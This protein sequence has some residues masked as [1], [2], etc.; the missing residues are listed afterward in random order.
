MRKPRFLIFILIG[1]LC[2]AAI[3]Q[4]QITR[5]NWTSKVGFK[6]DL[7]SLPVGAGEE[8]D[9]GN[10]DK[11]ASMLPPSVVLLVKNYG[12][13]YTVAD[14]KAVIPSDGFIAATNA[15]HGKATITETGP[16]GARKRGIDNYVAGLPV[17]KPK[18]GLEVAWNYHYGYNGDDAKNH[19]GVF[20]VSAKNGVER[21]EEW[22]WNYIMRGSNRTDIDPKPAFKE[23]V[24]EGK[25]Y[26]SLT[27][28]L[29]PFD[30]KGFSALYYRFNDPK[31]QEG[32]IYLPQQRRMTRFSFGTRGDAWNNTDML[33]EDVRGY[34]G[35]PEWMNWKV[36]KKTT[37]YAPVHADVKVGRNAFKETWDFENAPH[38]NPRLKWEPRPMYV[39]EATPKFRDYP[40]SKM[41][42]YI[43]AESF[44]M[45]FKECYDKKGQLWK[46]IM[47][48]TNKSP[49]PR[50]QPLAIAGALAVDLQAEHATTFCWYKGQ[51][52]AG[53]KP[54]QFSPTVL[55]KIGK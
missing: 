42:C 7:A 25:Q 37:M 31:D 5:S 33:Y 44:A 39:V 52:N 54:N 48:I 32:W 3:A 19:F 4:A 34:M 30:K 27:V 2:F 13:T 35:Y 23:W 11:V 8:V 55:R 29:A 17:L 20:W 41:I 46:V 51:M 10:V 12:L 36:I 22:T 1:V 49:N 26:S 18:N 15:N 47:N 50:K 53:L 21:S 16:K 28:T 38:W 6:P 14:H 9:S 43:D 24:G 45:A 40:Y